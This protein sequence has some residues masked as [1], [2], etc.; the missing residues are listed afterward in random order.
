M[1]SLK[2]QPP[3]WAET[4][5]HAGVFIS[6][7]GAAPGPGRLLCNSDW[8]EKARFPKLFARIG[9]I[10]STGSMAGN[11]TEPAGM[12]RLPN[13]QGRFLKPRLTVLAG[14]IPGDMEPDIFPN[15]Y[16]PA[17]STAVT[18]G[19]HTVQNWPRGHRMYAHGVLPTTQTNYNGH[20]AYVQKTTNIA[21]DHT[22]TFTT[23]QGGVGT[24]TR[25]YGFKT[26]LYI[27]TGELSEHACVVVY[28][29]DW[30]VT[31]S[32][33]QV[34]PQ[35]T[36]I[37]NELAK[38][39]I[40]AYRGRHPEAAAGRPTIDTAHVSI[41]ALLKKLRLHYKRVSVIAIGTGAHI[42]ARAMTLYNAAPL[43]DRFAGINGVYDP[44]GALG[45][46]LTTPLTNY[47]GGN[48]TALKQAAKPIPAPTP[49]KCW[50]APSLTES[51][52]AQAQGWCGNVVQVAGMA[53]N[54]NPI[55]AGIFNQVLEFL[56]S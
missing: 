52:L 25:P 39:N 17:T 36:Q 41:E 40:H 24:E 16:H 47:L 34:V 30:G 29:S 3:K 49:A 5:D 22:H 53:W 50:H 51:P 6:S 20:E 38:K 4:K 7:L 32:Y 2:V 10:Y 23:T 18:Q 54:S 13:P 43:V 26:P 35:L 44:T 19:A 27:H 55:S 33:N 28:G 56:E 46:S 15:H 45:A 8:V 9:H 11:G 42:V 31:P 1:I 48:T 12:F 14:E 21:G 37:F